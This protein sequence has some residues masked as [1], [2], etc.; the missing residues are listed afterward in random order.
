[1]S[2][3]VTFLGAV[4][5]VLVG[6]LGDSNPED[7]STEE[8]AAAQTDLF[9]ESYFSSAALTKTSEALLT[10]SALG[11][12]RHV[13]HR[14]PAVAIAAHALAS[15]I[16][17]SEE[18]IKLILSV[19]SGEGMEG[20]LTTSRGRPKQQQHEENVENSQKDRNVNVNSY[21]ATPIGNQVGL[22]MAGGAPHITSPYSALIPVSY[23]HLT[24]PTKRIV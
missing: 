12:Y 24:L 14:E 3:V 1:M 10:S 16:L 4:L 9:D 15:K 23:T 8:N 11:K 17:Y 20:R 21:G 5:R 13:H 18:N 2:I 7:S 22:S 6:L 19:V